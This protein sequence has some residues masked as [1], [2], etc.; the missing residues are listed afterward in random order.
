MCVEG[1]VVKEQEIKQMYYKLLT[2]SESNCKMQ[3]NYTILSI[4]YMFKIFQIESY[5]LT[6]MFTINN[7][8]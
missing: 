7:N 3:E 6:Y 5:S 1:G 2:I 8:I 4:F